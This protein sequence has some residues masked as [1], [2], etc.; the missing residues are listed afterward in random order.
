[1]LEEWEGQGSLRFRGSKKI[2]GPT[3]FENYE[4]PGLIGEIN[5]SFYLLK[6]GDLVSK[7][8]KNLKYY[9]GILA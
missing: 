1:M 4:G 6:N 9:K 7:N 2:I 5:M 3:T 8:Q